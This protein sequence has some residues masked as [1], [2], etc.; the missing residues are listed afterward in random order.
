M[1]YVNHC[2]GNPQHKWIDEKFYQRDIHVA[3][4]VFCSMELTLGDLLMHKD[5]PTQRVNMIPGDGL[6]PALY[7]SI[8][9]F[10]FLLG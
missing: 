9:R 7:K 2:E 6:S 3:G 4:M 1:V 5:A 8:T 10:I